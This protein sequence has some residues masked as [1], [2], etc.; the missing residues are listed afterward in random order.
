MGAQD[1]AWA[2]KVKR[3][4]EI[5]SKLEKKSQEFLDRQERRKEEE[6]K[7]LDSKR[8]ELEKS[9]KEGMKGLLEQERVQAEKLR[10]EKLH[11]FN[12]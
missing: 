1:Q 11:H 3:V 4:E 2:E 6:E 12:Q 9:I 10:E 5:E 8:Q 7:K